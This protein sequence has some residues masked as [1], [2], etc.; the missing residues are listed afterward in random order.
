MPPAEDLEGSQAWPAE[1]VRACKRACVCARRRRYKKDVI[2]SLVKSI[3]GWQ[4]RKVKE[5]ERG[6]AAAAAASAAA[7]ADS[8]GVANLRCGVMRGNA[9]R[10]RRVPG[11]HLH[12]APRPTLQSL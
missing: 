2:V 4:N 12:P 10:R 3:T 9:C 5:L 6:A 11:S 8:A 7:C 1:R